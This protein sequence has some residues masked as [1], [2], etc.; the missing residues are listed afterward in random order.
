[1]SAMIPWVAVSSLL[2]LALLGAVAARAGGASKVTGAL[3]VTFWGLLAMA[4]TTAIG[5]VIGT[6]I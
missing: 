6:V 2:F 1:M 4:A 3:R 5:R